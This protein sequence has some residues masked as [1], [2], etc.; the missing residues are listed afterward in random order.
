MFYIMAKGLMITSD[1]LKAFV[2]ILLI[3]NEKSHIGSYYSHLETKWISIKVTI[4]VAN[5]T[6]VRTSKWKVACCR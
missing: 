5:K 4:L 6:Q 3:I 2:N 1:L